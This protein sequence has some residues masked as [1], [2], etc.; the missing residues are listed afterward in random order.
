MKLTRRTALGAMAGALPAARLLAQSNDIEIAHGPFQGT[1]E[2]LAAY[3][4]PQ[5]FAD[6]KFGIWSHWGPQ[7]APED[8]DWYARN[9]YVEGSSQYKYHVEHYGHPSKVGFKDIDH[10][11][12][13][14]HWDPERLIDLYLER[15]DRETDIRVARALLGSARAFHPSLFADP[16]QIEVRI[17]QYGRGNCLRIRQL[18]INFEA[19]RAPGPMPTGP[20]AEAAASPS[21]GW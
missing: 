11:W 6:A 14:E 7:S 16:R 18:S 2:S 3:R 15:V 10:F 17:H 20:R 21:W 5:W 4:V 8:G 19:S 1:R 12:H 9:M 13:A